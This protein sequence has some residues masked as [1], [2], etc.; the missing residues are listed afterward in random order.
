MGDSHEM[1]PDGAEADGVEALALREQRDDRA[2][3]AQRAIDRLEGLRVLARVDAVLLAVHGHHSGRAQ[4]P[5]DE[6]RGHQLVLDDD[7]DPLLL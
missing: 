7:Q 3:L 6:G 5:P 2:I 4:D 1:A